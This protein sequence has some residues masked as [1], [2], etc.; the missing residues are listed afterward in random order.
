M[1]RKELLE[2]LKTAASIVTDS[3]LKRLRL[4]EELLTEAATS[5][6]FNLTTR[7]ALCGEIAKINKQQLTL[8]GAS[9]E[10]SGLVTGVRKVTK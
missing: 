3:E 9:V 5:G 2:T 6:N 8:L 1:D 10:Q 4:Y 7:K